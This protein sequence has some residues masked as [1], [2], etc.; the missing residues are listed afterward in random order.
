MFAFNPPGGLTDKSAFPTVP[1]NEDAARLQIQTPLNQLRDYI[2]TPLTWTYPTLTNGWVNYS[3]SD[4]KA[5]YAKDQ[6]GIVHIR[7]LIKA[8]V[9][10]SGTTLFTLPSGFR[11]SGYI[12]ATN[13]AGSASSRGTGYLVIDA[14][15]NV[16]IDSMP[17]NELVDILITPFL[18]EQ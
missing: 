5:S 11:P 6:F 1:A 8:G 14:I 9:M 15:G 16:S 7:G 18:A 17:Y 13:V 3:G 4:I 12:R 10:T 2:N